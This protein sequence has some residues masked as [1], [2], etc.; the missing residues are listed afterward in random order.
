MDVA[1]TT[2]GVKPGTGPLA[3]PYARNQ[4]DGCVGS[5]FWE[6]ISGCAGQKQIFLARRCGALLFARLT[7]SGQN[8]EEQL[9]WAVR[10]APVLGPVAPVRCA[11]FMSGG[12]FALCVLHVRRVVCAVRAS[13]QEGGLRCA[14]F[15]SGGWFALCVLR[16]AGGG[17]GSSCSC[18]E[19]EKRQVTCRLYVCQ[20]QKSLTARG[21]GGGVGCSSSL[22]LSL[23]QVGVQQ[24]IYQHRWA[25]ARWREI[26]STEQGDGG[27]KLRFLRNLS[28]HHLVHALLGRGP[29][30]KNPCL[31][32]FYPGK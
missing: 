15:M 5:L 7:S 29:Q 4:R 22:H 11:C 3:V 30:E 26:Q 32:S 18:V 25:G 12:W 16:Y 19:S 31:P 24:L 2:R 10:L 28:L 20:L 23:T 8:D 9:A 1:G 6:L 14:C 21:G 13:C 27:A 17:S